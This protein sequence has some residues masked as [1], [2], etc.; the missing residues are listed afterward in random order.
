MTRYRLNLGKI[1]EQKA[2]EFL[3][4]KGYRILQ[5]NFLS[6]L[7]E[8]DII[9]QDK[10]CLVFVEVKTR[11]SEKYG[12]PE[13][14]VTRTKIMSI[15]RTAEFFKLLQPQTPEAMRIDV[16]AIELSKKGS[17][18]SLRHHENVTG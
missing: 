1:G 12:L 2:G 3:Q 17:L 6:K 11:W 7:G 18:Y 8:I 4:N 16:I 10:D 15:T 14:A 13:E 5:K 9:A